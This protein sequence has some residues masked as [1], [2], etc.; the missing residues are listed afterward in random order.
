MHLNVL[1]CIYNVY[2][3]MIYHAIGTAESVT[4]YVIKKSPFIL[5]EYGLHCRGQK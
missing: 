3:R 2:I 5:H 4:G 1:F